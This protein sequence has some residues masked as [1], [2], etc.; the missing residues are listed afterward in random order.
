MRTGSLVFA[1]CVSFIGLLARSESL[2]R[3]SEDVYLGDRQSRT[4]TF[5]GMN[6][7][8]GRVVVSFRQR[9]NYPK[10]AGWCPCWQIQVNGRTLNATA[11]RHE[12]RLL[13]KPF[14]LGH[15][16]HGRYVADNRSDKWY[17]LYVPDF[18][19]ADD[20][21]ASHRE[22]ATRTVLDISD[23]VDAEGTNTVT[24]RAGG[25]KPSM[26]DKFKDIRPAVVFGEFEVRQEPTPTRLRR[27]E[28]K[29]RVPRLCPVAEPKFEVR[30]SPGCLAVEVGGRSVPVH[31][32]FTVPGGNWAEMGGGL[33]L[34]TPFYAVTRR[35]VRCNDRLDVFDTF[36]SR[37]NALI[38]VKVRYEIPLEGFEPV[39]VA[40]DPS[41]SAEKFEG[42]RNP[43][44]YGSF[45]D[46]TGG[47]AL[48]A[49]DDVFRV[50]NV[51]YCQDGRFGIRTEGV[52]IPPNGERTVEWSIYPTATDDYFEFVNAVRRDWDVNFEIP[53]SFMF[54]LHRYRDFTREEAVESMRDNALTMRSTA[55]HFWRHL[56][57][58]Y[59]EYRSN[60][61]GIGKNAER[62][63]VLMKDRSIILEDPKAMN[64]FEAAYINRCREL[65]PELKTFAYIHNQISVDAD[66][67][68]YRDCRVVTSRGKDLLYGSEAAKV[69][70]PTA[71]NLFGRDFLGLV[72]W[73]F[74]TFDLDGLYH[75]ELNHC[76]ERTYWG[77]SLWDGA[78][79]ELD[80]R[81]QVRRKY[82]FVCLLKLGFTVKLFDSV[83]NR[84]RKMLIGNFSPETR[85]ER[86]FKFPRFEETFLSR[87]IAL[88][89][90]YTP[91]Q[92]GDM[93]TYANTP[94]DMAADQRM[95]VRRGALYYHYSGN[96]G[97]PSLSS[98]MF[99]FTPIELHAGWLVGKERILTVMSGEFGWRGERP[100]V[101]VFVF[102]DC[103]REVR[104]YPY[105]TRD[106][107]LG[108]VF[109][110]DLKPDHSA[111]I[112]KR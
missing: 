65:T 11:T 54:S 47:L 71:D 106:T 81:F 88:S 7:A 41:P 84:H 108:R 74:K 102:D 36:V 1:V 3:E 99:P 101:D 27:I 45:E 90:L 82:S 19:A 59:A 53:G 68:K 31:S 60:I 24:L 61:W 80:E 92:L 13:N 63:R 111:A 94:K 40:G 96:T 107:P 57:G 87:W 15:R 77:D 42:G 50:Q 6:V 28:E 78:T 66:D 105:E 56:G 100:D 29:V 35:I 22:E 16:H 55:A 51:Q 21:F 58:K 70:V 32:R 20:L 9:I 18:H 8:T 44:V 23:L 48:L 83:L 93:L 37:T 98:K 52:A 17:A 109:V 97:C 86:R 62:V 30:R 103:G 89:H 43:S 85:T 75:D 25:L 76:N 14:A 112:V 91:I 79:V 26:W 73:Y 34:E 10:V 64:D 67:D 69:F 46:G 2:V 39:Y 110:L 4:W 5:G 72:D 33:S 49:Q 104:G 38:G 95:A 12:Q